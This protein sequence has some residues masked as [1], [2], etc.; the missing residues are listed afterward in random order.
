M[1][2]KRSREM[3]KRKERVRKRRRGMKKRKER[4]NKT[5]CSLP[6]S[7][8]STIIYILM[9]R[10]VTTVLD[11]LLKVYSRYVRSSQFTS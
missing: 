1:Q 2:S 9:W 11:C 6:L 5:F 8:K 3:K 4:E 7:S 10:F